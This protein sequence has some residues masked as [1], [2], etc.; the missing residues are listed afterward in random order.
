MNLIVNNKLWII[1]DTHFGHK[2]I[3]KFGQRPAGHELIMIS[4]WINRVKEDDQILHLGDVFVYCSK[5][6]ARRWAKLVSR[7]PG[8]KFL[9]FGNHD[10]YKLEI[11]LEAGFEPVEPFIHKGVAFTHEPVSD[12]NPIKGEWHMNVHGHTHQNEYVPEHDGILH[13]GKTY[14]N[15]CVEHTGLA[16]IQLGNIW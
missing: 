14:L 6:G 10:E 1:S 4:E 12:I 8:K 5:G 16:P 2:G 7:L 15:V 13:E 11:Y 9:I 3:L